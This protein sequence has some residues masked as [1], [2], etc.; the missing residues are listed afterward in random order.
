MTCMLYYW[1]PEV[2]FSDQRSTDCYAIMQLGEQDEYI[3]TKTT[4]GN[5]NIILGV[6]RTGLGLETHSRLSF[7]GL[8]LG[9]HGMKVMIRGVL[10]ERTSGM[11]YVRPRILRS[12][13]RMLGKNQF[14]GRM[15]RRSWIIGLNC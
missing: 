12:L 3:F 10:F 6:F 4:F 7:Q 1:F 5:L 8:Q 13:T 11:K 2:K 9:G 15:D 14:S